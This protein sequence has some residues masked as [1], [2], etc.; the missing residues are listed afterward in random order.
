MSRYRWLEDSQSFANLDYERIP[1]DYIT[2]PTFRDFIE[3]I[4]RI[5]D[6]VAL[7][8]EE[9]LVSMRERSLSPNIYDDPNGYIMYW[10]NIFDRFDEN[11]ELM[12]LP[13]PDYGAPPDYDNPANWWD[14]FF[15]RPRPVP[16]IDALQ[17]N[18]IQMFDMDDLEDEPGEYGIEPGFSNLG[19][20]LG[21]GLGGGL[22]YGLG[23]GLANWLLDEEK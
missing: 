14:D 6:I 3:R 13:Q 4:D 20:L 1:S 8:T 10:R 7:Y 23:D 2:D 21:G 16:G 5:R 17:Q 15:E 11:L 19:A 9:G 18:E 22:G 12:E